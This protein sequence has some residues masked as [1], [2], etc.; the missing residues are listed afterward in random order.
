M[1]TA[2]M[3]GLGGELAKQ[4]IA[5]VLTPAF[6]FWAGGLAALWWNTHATGVR[7]GG[8]AGELSTTADWL[9]GLP[10]LV[11]I[12]LVV[13]GLVLLAAS[14][15]AAESLTTPLLQFLEGYWPRPRWL[16]NRLVAY[17]RWRRRR[18][19]A[20][21]APLATRQVLGALKPLEY[22]ELI[23]L[24]AAPQQD[25]QRLRDLQERQ[26]QG[27]DAHQTLVLGRGRAFRHDSPERDEHGMP[28]RLGDIL[29][30]A[31]QRP[32][33]KYGLDAVTCWHA[34]VL[35][36]PAEART[37]LVQS[38]TALDASA[39]G[40]LWGALFLVWTPWT[41]WAIPVGLLVPSLMYYGGILPAARIFGELMV[42][43]FDVHRFMLYDSLRLP[44]PTTPILERE[45]EGP[46]VTQQLRGGLDEPGLTYREP[47][48]VPEPEDGP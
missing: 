43:A 5:R 26:R 4:W 40:W 21:I 28:T 17:R 13:G 31:E 46:R 15:L 39:R 29:R 2:F 41:W 14:A 7:Q 33:V 23:K 36:L 24:R 30:A 18:W 3:S 8:W 25:P 34:L 47:V 22:R 35:L 32:Q 48:P 1:L 11:Q 37:E 27:N 19:D 44:G 20:R 45:Q 6:T 38:R 16:R 42:A 9:G 10:V 12:L